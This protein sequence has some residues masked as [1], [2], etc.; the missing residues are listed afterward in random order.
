MPG[1]YA[2]LVWRRSW[3]QQRPGPRPMAMMNVLEIMAER[4]REGVAERGNGS[5][6]ECYPKGF[7]VPHIS[8]RS[9]PSFSN[10][11]FFL[12]LAFSTPPTT[13]GSGRRKQTRGEERRERDREE[14]IY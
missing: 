1:P 9:F 14:K 8:T 11:F 12:F 6:V 10:F 2:M 4:G 7:R 13:D 5:G 3:G